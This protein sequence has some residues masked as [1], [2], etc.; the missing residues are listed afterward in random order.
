[1]A[2]LKRDT[3]RFVQHC[4]ICQTTKGQSQNIDLYMP[5]PLSKHIWE[6]IQR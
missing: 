5:Q 6:D 1:M 2:Y 3:D 4:F